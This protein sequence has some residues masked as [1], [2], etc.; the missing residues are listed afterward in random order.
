[1]INYVMVYAVL[2]SFVKYVCKFWNIITNYLHPSISDEI[3]LAPPPPN[4]VGPKRRS[5]MHS[6]PQF[7]EVPFTP[8]FLQRSSIAVPVSNNKRNSS[9]SF[10][11]IEVVEMEVR[12]TNPGF[13]GKAKM[14]TIKMSI[15]MVGAFLAC[16]TPYYVMCIWWVHSPHSTLMSLLNKLTCLIVLT[17]FIYYISTNSFCG[18]WFFFE[19]GKCGIFHIV[20]ALWQFFTS[21]I[22]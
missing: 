6:L 10:N 16:W 14:N 7:L 9:A 15:A 2:T 1:M 22:E 19:C 3:T 8:L 11:K 18:N 20:S 12:R 21:W 4:A 5:F 17:H 13:I